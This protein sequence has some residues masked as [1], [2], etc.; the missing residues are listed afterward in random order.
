MTQDERR[1][2]SRHRIEEHDMLNWNAAGPVMPGPRCLLAEEVFFSGIFLRI[3][4]NFYYFCIR[5]KFKGTMLAK[6]A[7]KNF[8]GFADKIELDLT[9]HSNYS[10]NLY[11]IK[12]DI[13]KNGIVY[14]PNGSGK[15]NFSLAIFD[16]VNHVSQ[17]WKK[18]DYYANFAYAGDTFIKV[19]FEYTF[20]FD[21]Q[22]IE[23]NYSKNYQG[24]I[25]AE[26]L[27]VDGKQVFNRAEGKLAIDTGSF[28][29]EKAIQKNLADNANH[30]PI[31][32]FLLMSFPL[33]HDHYLIKMQQFVNGMLWFRSLDVREFIGLETGTTALEEYIIG[34]KLIDDFRR[35]L[36]NVSGQEFEFA[37]PRAGEKVLFCLIDKKRIPFMAIISTGT[38]SLELLYFWMKQMGKASFVFIDEFDAFYHFKLSFEVCKILFEKDCQVF[39]SSHNTYL[40][41]NDLLRP[42]CNFILNE[43]KIKPLVDCTEKELRFGHNIEKMF[44]ANAFKV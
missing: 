2:P 37:P 9:R 17:K 23:Y 16:I 32:N 1:N 5:N 24:I 39:T 4:E 18:P 34:N 8:R 25:T 13:I 21:G 31:V 35:F 33:A 10:F 7:V 20:I 22:K 28:P 14:G 36:A 42:D 27:V 29:M 40:M 11:A 43:N 15:T 3:Y 30:V 41:T 44:R 6:F 19:D 38:K 26:A 12:D